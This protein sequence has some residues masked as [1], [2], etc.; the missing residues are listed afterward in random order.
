MP[1]LLVLFCVALFVGGYALARK[2]LVRRHFE[3][4]PLRLFTCY[5]GHTEALRTLD[6]R[7]ARCPV[8]NLETTPSYTCD[9]CGAVFGL[10]P[11]PRRDMSEEE[12]REFDDKLMLCPYCQSKQIRPTPIIRRKQGD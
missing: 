4:G 9:K 11:W 7:N 6:L 1:A 2:A 8:C 5:R 3:Q 12:C 10:T